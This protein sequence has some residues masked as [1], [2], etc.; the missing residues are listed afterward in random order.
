MTGEHEAAILPQ[1][2]GP[3]FLGHLPGPGSRV[4]VFA[5]SFYQNGSP[6]HGSFQKYTLAQSKAV[7]PLPDNLSFEDGAVFPLAVL[8]ALTAWTTIG[9]SAKY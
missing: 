6:D 2:G 3:L 5:S 1:Q 7:I 4:I 8:T 9:I